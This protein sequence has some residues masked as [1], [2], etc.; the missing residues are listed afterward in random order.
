MASGRWPTPHSKISACALV[1]QHS[2]C[3]QTLL[4]WLSHLFI[5]LFDQA[6]MA[7]DLHAYVA[8]SQFFPHLAALHPG[9]IL[10]GVE[11]FCSLNT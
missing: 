7:I 11:Y 4:C 10:F 2:I 6:H 8:A 1:S 3:F 9:P 5:W